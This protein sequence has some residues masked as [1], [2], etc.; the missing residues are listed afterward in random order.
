MPLPIGKS[1]LLL[2]F[3]V[4]AVAFAARGY[5]LEDTR[6]PNG[7]YQAAYNDAEKEFETY[8]A[9]H[10]ED[11]RSCKNSDSNVQHIVADVKKTWEAARIA[12]IRGRAANILVRTHQYASEVAI[13]KYI[14]DN[15]LGVQENSYAT[16]LLLK[17]DYC[18]T[19]QTGTVYV[20]RN[21]ARTDDKEFEDIMK[22]YVKICRCTR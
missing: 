10:L 9:A 13:D 1:L 12:F 7:R 19:L 20:M 16:N 3:G 8:L 5:F 17:D 4:L 11:L 15:Y 2:L 14:S 6:E 18:P 21:L 22:H